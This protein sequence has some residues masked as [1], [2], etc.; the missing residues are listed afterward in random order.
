MKFSVLTSVNLWNQY[1]VD[2]FLE[3]IESVRN[4]TFRDFEWVIVDDG[5][6]LEVI[7]EELLKGIKARVIHKEHEER[8]IGYNEAFKNA[9]GNWF[10]LLDSD[11]ELVP[12]ALD[13]LNRM[14]RA[15]PKEKMFNFGAIYKHKDGTEVKRG[16]F[17]VPDEPFGGG[18]I[19]WGTFTFHRSIY[20]E[21]GGYPPKVMKDIDTTEIN[22]PPFKRDLH[23]NTPYD[24]SAYAQVE[25]P[26]IRQFFMVDHVNEPHKIIKELGN[27]WGNDFYLF[28]KYTRKYKSKTV[29]EYLYVVHPK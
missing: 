5:S 27:P 14:T 16:P 23:M 1:R 4:Q 17:I 18:N 13:T 19:V 25:F 28:Y 15:N 20:D 21:L 24:F 12:H 2:R 3:C 9:K 8:V 7:W 6:T 10:V 29:D 26:E 11:D 22:Y